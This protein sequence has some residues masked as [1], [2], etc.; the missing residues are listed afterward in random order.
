LLCLAAAWALRKVY[1]HFQFHALVGLC[2]LGGAVHVLL[3]VLNSYGVALL[4][5][6]S[7]RSFEMGLV[8]VADPMLTGVLVLPVI[9][10]AAWRLGR[11][12]PGAE[13][14]WRVGLVLVVG[15]VGLC[16]WSRQEASICLTRYLQQEGLQADATYVVPEPLGPH[17]WTGIIRSGHTYQVA[18]IRSMHGTVERRQVVESMADDPRVQRVMAH[19]AGTRVE[20]FLKAPVWRAAGDV[21]EARDLRFT[22]QVLHNEWD[23]FR[24][25]FTLSEDHVELREW[26]P[27]EIGSGLLVLMRNGS[28]AAG[29]SPGAAP[30]SRP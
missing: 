11:P 12:G 25:R 14:A 7:S 19:V 29:T 13:A 18:L 4:A 16:A 6:V 21:V 28:S 26:T 22:Y 8:F 2:L 15:Y 1:G 30:R 23:P 9:V 20:R 17:R 27:G 3:D 10:V 24:F 5:P